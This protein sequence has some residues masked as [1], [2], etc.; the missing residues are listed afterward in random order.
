MTRNG[1]Q[2]KSYKD[3]QLEL[4]WT[5]S[6]G[7]RMKGPRPWLLQLDYALLLTHYCS[8]MCSTHWYAIE[9]PDSYTS[10]PNTLPRCTTNAQS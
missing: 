2:V 8:T 6:K 5:A 7:P 4:A 3:V 1:T 10:K 9:P